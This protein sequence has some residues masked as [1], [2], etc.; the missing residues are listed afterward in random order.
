M[1]RSAL[2]RGG[3]AALV[4]GSAALP[5]LSAQIQ[6]ITVPKG[7]LRWDFYGRFESYDWRW[8]DGRREEAAGDFDAKPLDRNFIPDLGPTEDRLARIT[9]LNNLGLTLGTSR[10]SKLVTVGTL[11]IGGAVGV[12]RRI[13]LFGMIPIVRVQVEPRFLIDT[14]VANAGLSPDN[15]VLVNE[16]TLVLSALNQRLN[17]DRVYDSDPTLKS[18]AQATLAKIIDLQLLLA[19]PAVANFVPRVGTAAGSAYL[20]AIVAIQQDLQG[21]LGS[22]SFTAVPN[23]PTGPIDRAIF[24]AYL[25]DPNGTIQ[26]NPLDPVPEVISMGDIEVGAAFS[27][28]DRFPRSDLGAGARSVLQATVRLRTARLATPSRV[29]SVATGD[30]QPD[31]EVSWVTDLTRGRLG[32]RL[33]VGYNLQLPGNQNK[34]VT[35]A[36]RPF[37]LATS[38][39]GTRRDPGDVIRLTAAPFLRLAPY[40]SIYGS[41]DYWRKGVD[42]WT[43]VTG[44]TPVEGVDI[45]ALARGSKSDGLLLSGGISYSHSGLDKYGKTK[46]PLDATILYQRLVRSATGIVPDANVVRVDLRFYSNLWGGGRP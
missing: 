23:L 11:G 26:L 8:N 1:L 5:R 28:F 32:T 29:F 33:A 34:R 36:D 40:L 15:G 21:P 6:P 12:T 45:D 3:L 18:L 44:Q 25:T 16:L 38:L 22:T 24:D 43:Y 41:A 14:T 35:P 4:F 39:A 2:F 13:T 9:G 19:T 30:R 37:S 42:R 31:V 27:L 7:K 10:S 46:L 17:I 20:A